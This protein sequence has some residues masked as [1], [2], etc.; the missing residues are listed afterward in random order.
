MGAAELISTGAW[1]LLQLSTISTPPMTSVMR[2]LMVTPAQIDLCP[3][4]FPLH[5]LHGFWWYQHGEREVKFMNI[6]LGWWCCA[7]TP[8]TRLISFPPE[9]LPG[10][11]MHWRTL[12]SSS[13]L[14][15]LIASSKPP[16]LLSVYAPEFIICLIE[17][18][19]H[20]SS[21]LD[22]RNVD[23]IGSPIV[24]ENVSSSKLTPFL[25]VYTVTF[26]AIHPRRTQNIIS[27]N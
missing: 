6:A 18:K 9:V 22:L 17:S 21:S 23:L 14:N 5:G 27:P 8:T 13:L 24:A 12:N 26:L 11:T 2:M 3:H 10:S 7:L 1:I 15:S 4:S 25:K 16:F 20:N 19:W